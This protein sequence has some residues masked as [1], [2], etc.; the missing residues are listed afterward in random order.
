M[1][2]GTPRADTVRRAEL[3]L[4]RPYVTPGKRVLE[5]GTGTG[6]Q[7][8]VIQSWGANVVGLEVEGRASQSRGEVP[9]I[10]YDGFRIPLRD[11]C[12]DV[13]Y[14]SCVLEHVEQLHALLTETVR[15]LRPG[16]TS[17]HLVPTTVWRFWSL[18]THPVFA[19]REVK[20][21]TDRTVRHQPPVQPGVGVVAATIPA[22][23]VPKLKRVHR[24]VLP[25]AH[26][27]QGNALS[28][29]TRW[30]RSEWQR[31]TEAAGLFIETTVPN[32]YFYTGNGTLPRLTPRS[33]RRVTAVLGSPCTAIVSHKE[34]SPVQREAL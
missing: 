10:E 22:G 16:G 34:P 31:A 17:V 28:E 21:F 25:S 12:V 19:A 23:F 20:R 30:R 3:E 2:D 29:L 8:A 18:A 26:G 6:E 27:V 14:S 5:L 24:L 4:L 7:A 32:R 11:G 1:L 15:V 13:V 9:V 33:R